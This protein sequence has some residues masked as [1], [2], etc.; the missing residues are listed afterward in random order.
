MKPISRK[1]FHSS[2]FIN[3]DFNTNFGMKSTVTSIKG[4][5]KKLGEKY[6]NALIVLYIKNSLNPV[7]TRKPDSEGSYQFLGINNDSG[8]FVVGLDNQKQYNAVIQDQV[9]PK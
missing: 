2:D 8:F 6:T 3:G 7:A 1:V 9:V 5:V 4:S